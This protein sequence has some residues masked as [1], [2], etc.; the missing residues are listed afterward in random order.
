MIKI[1]VG[2]PIHQKPD[3]LREFLISLKELKKDEFDI[4]YCFID[5]NSIIE[6]SLILAKFKEEEKKVTILKNNNTSLYICDDY[7]HRWSNELID[8]VAKFKNIIIQI[9][10]KE[11]F[12][13]LFLIDSDLILHPNTLKRLVSLNKEIISN[14]KKIIRVYRNVKE[15]WDL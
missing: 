8:K 2:S 6:S 9:A 1:L 14:F 13:Y 15:T 7:T 10:I 5:D 11:N 3:I 4:Q 12:D